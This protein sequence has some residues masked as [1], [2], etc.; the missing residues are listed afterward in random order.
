MSVF[1]T[2]TI[3][4]KVG[5]L[6]T[7][8][9]AAGGRLDGLNNVELARRAGEGLT[10]AQRKA[11]LAKFKGD[12][13]IDRESMWL[14]E[15]GQLFGETT[16]RTR[17]GRRELLDQHLISKE[18]DV[19]ARPEK[20]TDDTTTWGEM[21]ELPHKGRATPTDILGAERGRD[22]LAQ[23]VGSIKQKL[24]RIQDAAIQAEKKKDIP[25]ISEIKR[26]LLRKQSLKEE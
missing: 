19:L 22:N 3:P 25:D 10:D 15:K 12:K 24:L 8:F 14:E 6:A 9:T 26:R 20:L 4:K 5:E 21:R 1:K 17:A 23:G 18:L 7:Q 13:Y 2:L 16:T 11:L